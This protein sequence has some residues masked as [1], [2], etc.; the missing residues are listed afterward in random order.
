VFLW[1]KNWSINY[2]IKLHLQIH[3]AED[4]SINIYSRN[5]ENNT[6]KY[7]DI[8]SR[9]CKALGED[10][11]SCILDCEAVA[12]DKEKQQILPFQV[13]ST[14]KRKVI[15]V[16]FMLLH[17]L[18][19]GNKTEWRNWLKIGVHPV[20]K[21]VLCNFVYLI[22]LDVHTFLLLQILLL[23]GHSHYLKSEIIFPCISSSMYHIQKCF[24]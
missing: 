21:C 16:I 22:D 14:R 10:T 19:S 13:L 18:V 12:W 9:L 3:L 1:I 15:I 2:A 7:P 17:G 4:G 11:T 24:K 20:S 23:Q 8:T 6:S 5:Q